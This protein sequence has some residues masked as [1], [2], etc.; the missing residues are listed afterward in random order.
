M[1]GE[2]IVEHL[3]IPGSLDE[4]THVHDWTKRLLDRGDVPGAL[5]HNVLLALS[6]CVTNAIRHGCKSDPLKKV[7]LECRCQPGRITFRVRDR[8][9]GFV[10]EELPDPTDGDY[11]LRAGG[12]GVYLLKALAHKSEIDTSPNGTTVTFTF[13]WA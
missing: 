2:E 1:V 9:E 12:R 11:L 8:G 5:Q 7:K 4:L 6:E 13:A 10:P 3:V